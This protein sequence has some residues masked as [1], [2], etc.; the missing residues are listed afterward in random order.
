MS[1]EVGEGFQIATAYIQLTASA[2]GLEAEAQE[3]L[4]AAVEG[5]SA[6]VTLDI[7]ITD[8]LTDGLD[9]ALDDAA[10]RAESI[11]SDAGT[12]GGEAFNEGLESTTAHAGQIIGEGLSEG[13]QEAITGI[14]GEIVSSL[15]AAGAQGRDALEE[16]LGGAITAHVGVDTETGVGTGAG[17]SAAQE[18]RSEFESVLSSAVLGSVIGRS[19]SAAAGAGAAS[20]AG[21][22]AGGEFAQS[23]GDAAAGDISSGALRGFTSALTSAVVDSASE[24]GDAAGSEMGRSVA[25]AA[26]SSVAGASF[27]SFGASLTV[28]ATDFGSE[29]GDAGGQA[30]GTAFGET[31]TEV[32]EE[33]MVEIG[34][35]VSHLVQNTLGVAARG[36]GQAVAEGV[37]SAIE[38]I[39]TAVEGVESSTVEAMENV[40]AAV[41]ETMEAADLAADLAADQLARTLSLHWGPA[42]ASLYMDMRAGMEV[43][44]EDLAQ[45][46]GKSVIVLQD[47]IDLAREYGQELA[48]AKALNIYPVSGPGVS[49][50]SP[51][52]S[53]STVEKDPFV[54][55]TGSVNAGAWTRQ[56]KLAAQQAAA[57]AAEEF[58]EEASAGLTEAATVAGASIPK[59]MAAGVEEEMPAVVGSVAE[60]QELLDR[61]LSQGL[62]AAAA[63]TREWLAEAQAEESAARQAGSGLITAYAEGLQEGGAEIEEALSAV[64]EQVDEQLSLFEVAAAEAHEAGMQISTEL[65]EGISESSSEIEGQLSLLDEEVAAGLEEGVSTTQRIMAYWKS[66]WSDIRDLFVNPELE[67]EA[68]ALWQRIADGAQADGGG[69]FYYWLNVIEQVRDVFT[70][71]DVPEAAASLSERINVVMTEGG[72]ATGT[73]AGQA[74][75]NGFVAGLSG[76]VPA[77]DATTE[78]IQAVFAAEDELLTRLTAQMG[79]PMANAFMDIRAGLEATQEDLSQMT[80][81]GILD[82]QKLTEEANQFGMAVAEA[83]AMKMT[84]PVYSAP[85][86]GGDM[87]AYAQDVDEVTVAGEKATKSMEGLGGLMSGPLMMAMMGVMMVGPYIVKGLDDIS[88]V[89]DHTTMSVNALSQS[90]LDVNA[91]TDQLPAGFANMAAG[92]G[93]MSAAMGGGAVQGLQDLDTSLS[94]LYAT[95][96]EL[97]TSEFNQM[98]KS[99]EASGLS[100]SQVAADFP[101]YTAA[102]QAAAL[103]TKEQQVELTQLIPGTQVFTNAVNTQT[104][105]LQ[106][107]NA[108]Q[109]VS[110]TALNNSL[111]PQQRLTQAAVEAGVAY[112]Q[113]GSATSQYTNALTALYGQF[114]NT[115]E[116]EASFTTGLAGLTG[117]IT[118]G[119]SAVE[120][121]TAA[122]A[123]NFTQ[124][125]TVAQAAITYSEDLYTQTKSSSQAQTALQHMVTQL[126]ATARQAGL[127]KTQV[128]QLNTE[129]FGVP[130]PSEIVFSSNAASVQAQVQG[131]INT[132]DKVPV[133]K[134]GGGITEI[135][136]HATGGWGQPGETSIVGENGPEMITFGTDAYVT[137]NQQLTTGAAAA[138]GGGQTSNSYSF[139]GIY[140]QGNI[141][142]LTNPNA[143]SQAA[144]KFVWQLRNALKV[145][146][147]QY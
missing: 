41:E 78:E 50:S 112:T 69:I 136:R 99:M 1:E 147:G 91:S 117:S 82:L 93:Q 10:S 24:A 140:V 11:L 25:D 101:K 40:S 60:L 107:S 142:D 85:T 123:K 38:A 89:G 100:T 28:L 47:L 135:T 61:Q 30:F 29:A 80:V 96:P 44:E 138:E 2:D 20:E 54:K 48:D 13:V 130:E 68:D 92:L 59:A 39:D 95:N 35:K 111:D 137:T 66:V 102:V 49:T 9:G 120:L 34:D 62:L 113:A 133:M 81:Q 128:Q 8:S 65:A 46:A 72:G 16:G 126:D 108:Q 73:A 64:S 17:A 56:S 19:L 37:D 97:A 32:I 23:V 90:F 145:V 146:D 139:G 98:A 134:G 115:S 6:V 114:G 94:N 67:E 21:G 84:S 33:S 70:G 51:G 106:L 141:P 104:L 14:D 43:S 105:S 127:T 122:G 77:A 12:Q 15:A 83:S 27:R 119:T 18:F 7:D 55:D 26:A 36:T 131:L 63:E 87:V 132:V 125:Q 3:L 109:L 86:D 5:L 58:T 144:R 74:I 57:A 52:Q 76:L 42:L 124:F 88:G 71:S 53:V 45:F 31:V 75:R 129:L 103:A 79:G 110:A 22:A 4:D 121:N 116:A 118:R 143:L